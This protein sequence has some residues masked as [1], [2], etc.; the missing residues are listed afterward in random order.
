MDLDIPASPTLSDLSKIS[1]SNEPLICDSQQTP[2][3]SSDHN[4]DLIP[5]LLAAT[6]N[7]SH[8][9]RPS[10]SGVNTFSI[11]VA[12]G[13]TANWESSRRLL[14]EKRSTC[15]ASH[16]FL[17]LIQ[18]FLLTAHSLSDDHLAM[19]SLAAKVWVDQLNQVSSEI[20]SPL[21]DL[22]T[23][24]SLPT[25]FDSLS[26]ARKEAIL[27]ESLPSLPIASPGP[28]SSQTIHLTDLGRLRNRETSQLGTVTVA[29]RALA[30]DPQAMF[31]ASPHARIWRTGPHLPHPRTGWKESDLFEKCW[32][33]LQ[34]RW[35]AFTESGALSPPVPLT[36]EVDSDI[37]ENL[38][39]LHA[40]YCES[41]GKSSKTVP[42]H[43]L[44]PLAIIQAHL[45]KD[46][47]ACAHCTAG[48][49]SI[50][51]RAA[52]AD[53]APSPFLRDDR[54]VGDSKPSTYPLS[55]DDQRIATAEII[56]YW[57]KGV[58]CR[59]PASSKTLSHPYFVVAKYRMA[60]PLEALQTLY[61]QEKGKLASH[62]LA[63]SSSVIDSA[64][65]LQLQS[66]GVSILLSL[67]A[68]S[69]N[70]ALRPFLTDPKLRLVMDFGKSV[71]NKANADWPFSYISIG[72]LLSSIRWGSWV[73][74]FDISAAFVLLPTH[75]DDRD[76][77]TISLPAS[78]YLKE[79]RLQKG[80]FW[81]ILRQMRHLFGTKFL[82]GQFCTISAEI[83]DTLRR[84]FEKYG[85]EGY[86]TFQAYM[87]DIFVISSTKPLCE[88]ACADL[89]SYM[90]KIGAELNDKTRLPAQTN[91]PL[92]GVEVDTLSMTV[93]LPLAKAYSTAF[94]CGLALEM[95]TKKVLPP[96]NFWAKLMGKLE[97]ASYATSGGAGRLA[98]IR[99]AML[100]SRASIDD[101][102]KI[103]VPL[104]DSAQLRDSLRWWLHALSDG[105]PS[106]RLFTSCVAS[107]PE[108]EFRFKSDAAGNIGAGLICSD[109][110]LHLTWTETMAKKDSIQ[111]KELMP[112]VLFIERYGYLLRGLSLSFGT[113]N[114]S[115]VYS[116]NKRSSRDPEALEWL[117]Y[118]CDLADFHHIL[119]LPSWSPREN[120]GE[121][122]LISKSVSPDLVGQIYPKHR[123]VL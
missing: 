70:A 16:P 101:D 36:A 18:E 45:D 28:N 22:S 11:F 48:V 83:V 40:K 51:Q 26:E 4:C 14:E 55:E 23:V 6:R 69:L 82:P 94:M 99:H 115:N 74:S 106:A 102:D 107:S 24:V 92:L 66:L 93:S 33:N 109:L 121:A 71:F 46:I 20:T 27:K 62:L 63:I 29:P 64:L 105:P 116:I 47:S 75:P 73:A 15:P 87:D 61:S 114:V 86:T 81:I 120:N 19:A 49:C 79:G 31:L 8:P 100:L 91:I 119:L 77:L 54:P 50:F 65:R 56:G 122:D 96:D 3:S 80:D 32:V 53:G 85:A 21:P 117:V 118:L 52:L 2:L 7:S 38:L 25:S 84:R 10:V 44:D 88:K 89:R 5:L 42:H 37:P 58:L 39:H 9:I 108:S 67:D 43:R 78:G 104:V 123:R 97:H 13:Q 113:D 17:P 57:K 98:R 1:A 41:K 111:L 34:N 59:A 35:R 12:P 103:I 90:A 60:P 112:I 68:S 72:R 95:I 30:I 110:V 76:L